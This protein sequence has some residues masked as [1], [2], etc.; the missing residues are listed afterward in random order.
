MDSTEFWVFLDSVEFFADRNKFLQHFVLRSP[1]DFLHNI[2]YLFER[3][4]VHSRF[5]V[6]PWLALLTLLTLLTLFAA[7]TCY[8]LR[9]RYVT[10]TWLAWFAVDT[11][12]AVFTGYT[13]RTYRTDSALKRW[14][15]FA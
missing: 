1:D 2:C 8:T 11:W 14:M 15:C 10:D 7:F 3:D 6:L 4:A 12:L 5:T 13:C 9:P